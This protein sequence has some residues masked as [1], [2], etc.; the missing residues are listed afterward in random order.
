MQKKSVPASKP[1]PAPDSVLFE[2]VEQLKKT[3]SQAVVPEGLKQKIYK[4]LARLKRMARFGGYSQ[5]YDKISHYLDWVVALPWAKKTEDLLDL[6]YAKQVMDKHHYGMEQ[7]KERILEF[8][9]ILKLTQGEKKISR[10]PILCLVGLVGTGKTTFA[11]SL[12]EAMKRRYVRIPFGGMGSAL[13]LRGQSRL[14]PDNEPGQIIKALKRAQSNNP[15]I[16]LDEIDRVGKR[17]RPDIMGVLIE[18]LDPEQNQY[19]T[20]HYI[21]YPF[22]LSEVLFLATCNNTTNIA[23]AVLDRMEVI[24]M[25]SYSDDEK[26]VIAKDYLLPEAMEESGLKQENLEIDPQV[27]PK[28][29]RPLGFDAGMRSLERAIQKICRKVAKLIVEKKGRHFHVTQENLKQFISIY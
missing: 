7:V 25:P 26:I 28:I 11:V 24:R 17:A 10:A 6:N 13:D 12:A 22:D 16:L 27:W 8:L 14:H 18:L 20:D 3:V 2:E 5:E 1:G 4:M 19:F 23:T 15:V 9:S 29:V 21:D